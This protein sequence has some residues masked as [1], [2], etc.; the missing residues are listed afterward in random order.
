MKIIIGS[1]GKDCEGWLSTEQ[2]TLDLLDRH[3]FESTL[4][5]QVGFEAFLAEHVLEHLSENDIVTALR[6]CF[7]Y[8]LIG[9][10][11]RIAVPDGLHPNNDYIEYVKPGGNGAGADSHQLL[12]N[13]RMLKRWLLNIGYEVRLLEW[14]DELGVFHANLW[15]EMD[16][17]IERCAANDPRNRDGKLNYTS[18]IVDGIK[19][20]DKERPSLEKA[21][22]FVEQNDPHKVSPFNRKKTTTFYELARLAPAGGSI[23]ELGVYHGNGTAALWYGSRDGHRCKVVAVD[24]FKT[25]KGWAGEPYE[26][27][28]KLIWEE[29]MRR[30]KIYPIL[31][32]RDAKE[33]SAIWNEPIS[34]LVHD[35]GSMKRMPEDIMDWERHIIVGGSIALRDLDNY[36]MGTEKAVSNLLSTNRWGNRKNWDGFITSLERLA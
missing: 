30:A 14:W 20:M 7:D 28:D 36:S 12:I 19:S 25:M 15:N 4:G 29:N 22:E 27:E 2:S 9:G 31:F 32:Q 35:L 5:G 13:Y 16:G 8:L 10:H 3:T 23:V 1:G 18:L 24:A 17:C 6:N 21:L 11:F 34:L 33:L 26:P